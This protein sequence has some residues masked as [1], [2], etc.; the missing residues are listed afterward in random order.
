VSNSSPCFGLAKPVV[1]LSLNKL[2]FANFGRQQQLLIFCFKKFH[3]RGMLGTAQQ[4]Q[5]ITL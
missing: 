1:W 3:G 5:P 2:A 4:A